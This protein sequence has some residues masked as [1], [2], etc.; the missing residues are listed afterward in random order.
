MCVSSKPGMII[1]LKT[2]NHWWPLVPVTETEIKIEPPKHV[3]CIE[4]S[5]SFKV[6]FKILHMINYRK[7]I[8]TVLNSPCYIQDTNSELT[9]K[10][11]CGPDSLDME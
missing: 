1:E 9:L 10:S 8:R 6:G 5:L 2:S 7:E 4:F 11:P 3:E